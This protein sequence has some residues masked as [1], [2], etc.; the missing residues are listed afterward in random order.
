MVARTLPSLIWKISLAPPQ[1]TLSVLLQCQL[2]LWVT[3]A[4][5][6]AAKI[7]IIQHQ[8]FWKSWKSSTSREQS[9][10]WKFCFLPERNFIN[11]RGISHK[12]VQ[13]GPQECL[14]ISIVVSPDPF[15]SSSSSPMK[16]PENT[17][18]EPDD[19]EPAD[20]DIL[21]AFSPDYFTFHNKKL[22]VRIKV[23]IGTIW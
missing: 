15:T 1:Y 9:Q 21:M 3:T 22:P 13:I 20:T 23:N 17:Q 16:T 5:Q 18:E 6:Y 4:E 2:A 19:P 8:P 7:P 11:E 12:H 10:D 14:Y